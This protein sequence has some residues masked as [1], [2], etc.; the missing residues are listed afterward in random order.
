MGLKVV[1]MGTPLFAK[2]MLQGL[3]ESKYPVVGVVTVADKPAGRGQKLQESEVKR[4]AQAQRIPLLQPT[5]LKDPEFLSKLAAFD[6]DLFVVVAFRMLP[7]VV[8][9]MPRMGTINLHASLLPNYRGAAPIHWAIM[10]GEEQTG[11]STFFIN[12]RIDCGELLLQHTLNIAPRWTTGILHDAMLEPGSQL[13]LATLNALEQGTLK[14]T[15]QKPTSDL[16]EAPKL[17]KLNTRIHPQFSATR[18]DRLVRGLNPF[19]SA[20]AVFIDQKSLKQVL[21]KI[22]EGFPM[23]GT[24]DPKEP[25]KP[26]PQGILIPCKEGYFCVTKLQLEGK[27]SMDFKAFLAGNDPT[28]FRLE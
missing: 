21:C 8:W 18:I 10:N 27:K 13:I 17:T 3:L 9:N 15:P 16:K 1:F 7:E 23:D 11:L 28:N 6:A 14:A 20:Y 12:D 5:S 26:S 19:P 24:S 4:L 2:Y 25:L 22:H